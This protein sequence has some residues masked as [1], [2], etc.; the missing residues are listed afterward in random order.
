MTAYA[1]GRL[2]R[3]DGPVHSRVLDYLRDVEDTLEP[4]GGR[5]L[6]HGA[7]VDVREGQW[8]GDVVLIAFPDLPSAQGWYDSS[9]YAVIRPWRTEHIRGDVVLVDGVSPDHH[10]VDLTKALSAPNVSADVC[11]RA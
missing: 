7:P 8:E 11:E 1:L 2:E 6:V 9:A 4:F 5:F 10:A 3:P